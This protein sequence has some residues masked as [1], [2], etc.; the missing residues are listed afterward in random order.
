MTDFPTRESDT[1]FP[2][3]SS[4]PQRKK[5][6]WWVPPVVVAGLLLLYA[7]LSYFIPMELPFGGVRLPAVATAEHKP[8]VLLLELG[9]LPEWRQSSWAELFGAA[10]QVTFREALD[11][12]RAAQSDSAVRGL[13]LRLSGNALGWAKREELAEAIAEL[14]RHGKFVYAFIQGGAEGDYALALAA[15]SI[16]MA[17]GE[18]L[19]E[20]NG[21]AASTVFWAGLLQ[22]LGISFHVEQFEEYKSAAEPYARRGY[23]PAA[24][25]N[26]RALLQQRYRRF[27]SW[28]EQRR[29]VS[30][31]VLRDRIFPQGIHTADSLKAWG[32]ID[33][34]AHETEVYALLAHRLGLEDT[35]EVP[36]RLW[37]LA[38]YIRSGAM[39]RWQKQAAESPAIGIVYGVGPIVPGKAPGNPWDE[40][41]IAS[42]DF[43]AA[44]RE[45][46]RDEDVRAI[47]VRIESPGGSVVASD[48]IWTE[49]RRIARRKPV[50]ASMGDVAASGGYYIA[51]G[52]DSIIA[53]PMTLTGSIGVIMALPNLAATMDKLGL[54]VDTVLSNPGALFATGLLPFTEQQKQRFHQIGADF[55]GQFLQK[56]AQQRRMSLSS[57]RERA[58]GRVWTGEEAY[59]VGLVDTVGGLSTAIAIAKR[60]LGIAEQV[61]VAI[62][63]FPRRKEPFE[64]LLEALD[65]ETEQEETARAA[66]ALSLVNPLPS[67]LRPLARYLL[68]LWELSQREPLLV[69]LPPWIPTEL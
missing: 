19:L 61:P 37:S 55:Y 23:S 66:Y 35:L 32:L 30:E 68:Q 60:R 5:T 49:L 38:R 9:D 58:R 54:R 18:G 40:A 34:I 12:L 6:P 10:R 45:A 13:Y 4:S 16:F 2:T 33:G 46:E 25:E 47:I 3:P 52:C 51:M 41:V 69:A 11:A 50:Y 57:V 53:H 20:L 36:K 17:P 15:D 39:R 64:I 28:V 24:R 67:P 21:F 65:L 43:I 48:A 29:G 56:V 14:R 44:L 59:Q 8:I 7:V 22:K 1:P 26:L 27:V 62:R 63:E 31:E 42:D